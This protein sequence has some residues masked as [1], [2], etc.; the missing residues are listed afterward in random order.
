MN[1]FRL[2]ILF[3]FLW[4][5][6]S[7]LVGQELIP[8]WVLFLLVVT[9][10]VWVIYGSITIHSN[11]F[12]DV[13][14]SVDKPKKLALTFDDGPHPELTNKMLDLLDQKGVKATFFCIGNRVERH[15]EIVKEISHRGHIVAN[16][17]WSHPLI[18]GMMPGFLVKSQMEKCSAIIEHTI[19][20]RPIFFRPPFGVINPRV[21]R[22]IRRLGV[23]TIGWNL[24]SRDGGPLNRDQIYR[25]VRPKLEKGSI[26]LF[27]DTNAETYH[28]LDRILDD[29]KQLGL[30]IVPL[31]QLIEKQAYA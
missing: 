16:H 13:V 30:D 2:N 21:R 9:Y 24:R 23:E 29:C 11:F 14:C 6:A 25:M 8:W 4:I 27:H 7:Y 5:G 18:W 12:M 26:M 19:G 31:D 28:A 15:P 20:K 10:A 3:A 1:F 22:F 17:T